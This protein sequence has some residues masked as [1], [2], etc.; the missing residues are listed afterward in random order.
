MWSQR[1]KLATIDV[2]KSQ[3][4]VFIHSKNFLTIALSSNGPPIT[5]GEQAGIK[6]SAW[7]SYKQVSSLSASEGGRFRIPS[8]GGLEKAEPGKMRSLSLRRS[9]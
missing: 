6:I 9:V 4:W 3:S 5:G 1:K 8:N 7:G 2:L